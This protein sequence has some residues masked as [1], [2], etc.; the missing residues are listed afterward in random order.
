MINITPWGENSEESVRAFE[1][2]IGFALPA[3]YRQF[4]TKNNGGAVNHQT[5]FVKDLGQ[6]VLMDVMYGLTNADARS[7]TLGYWIKEYEEE[8]GENELV[9]R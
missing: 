6:E 7:L 4:L 2:Q 3:D 9:I 5:F 1:Q 8:V